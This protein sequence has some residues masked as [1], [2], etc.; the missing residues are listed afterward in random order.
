MARGRPWYQR[1]PADWI[2]GT[3]GLTLEEKG[4]YGDIVEYLNERD[5]AL[6]DEDRIIAALIE[7][8]VRKWRAIREVLL[9]KGK[10]QV[11]H[12]YITNPRFER[13]KAERDLSR[14]VARE[15]GRKGGKASAAKRAQTELDLGENPPER[16]RAYGETPRNARENDIS[17]VSNRFHRPIDETSL[18][19]VSQKT[20]NKSQGYPQARAR[21]IDQSLEKKENIPQPDSTGDSREKP[22][23]RMDLL[24]QVCDA[25]GFQPT[26]ASAID[27]S[28]RVVEAWMK[29]GIDFAEVVIPTIQSVIASNPEPT[30]T[31]GR[32]TKY[33]AHEHARRKAKGTMGQ[34]YIPPKTPIL[35]REDEPSAMADLRSLLAQVL[36]PQTFAIWFNDLKL[37]PDNERP[38]V[39]HVVGRMS[40]PLM[41]SGTEPTVR[42]AARRMGFT[43]V[44]AK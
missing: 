38:N 24:H 1:Y 30:R 13:E 21:A 22:D 9:R 4:A 28:L 5:H 3:R 29:E 23:D 34:R 15:D 2:V 41:Q 11:V 26:S 27:R 7:C 25:S 14:A 19:P 12:G 37:E 32:F 40:G 10:L 18:T 20:A 35:S 17:A 31:L 43:D 36:G 33:I 6:P 8:S 39:L 42:A 16:A 44:F